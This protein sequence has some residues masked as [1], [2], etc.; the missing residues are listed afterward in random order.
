MERYD[1][2]IIG[3]GPS[4]SAAA[5]ALA[6]S[7]LNVLVVERGKTPGSKNVFGGRIYSYPLF[8]LIPDWQK[9]CPVERYVTKDCFAFMTE[10]QS[11]M[12]QF[13]SP[14]L[15]LGRGASFTALRSQ[16]DNWLAQKAESAGATLITEIKVD[17]LW[18]EGGRARG[19]VA[20]KD[21]IGADVVIAADGVVSKFTQRLGLRAELTPQMVSIGI[22]ETVA[23]PSATIQE[24]FGVNEG[25]GAAYVLAG[26]ASGHL[27]GGGFIYTNKESVSLGLVVSSE[28]VSINKVEVQ[29][30][31]ENFKRH[32][33]IERLLRGGKVIEYSTHMIPELGMST[34]RRAYSDGFLAVGDAAGFL[35]NNGYTFRGVDLAIASGMAAAEAVEVARLRGDFSDVTLAAYEGILR[36]DGVL[37]DLATFQK[38][39]QYMSNPRLY[40]LYPKLLCDVVERIFMIDGSGQQKAMDAVLAEIKAKNVSFFSLL[41]DFIGGALS[42]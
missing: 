29:S 11:L 41:R 35:I 17:D 22:K 36:R 12:V 8:K 39:P 28:D 21:K 42:M 6:K 3:A 26:Y 2:V 13:E 19:I 20:G 30:L 4:G 15:G 14:R 10:D 31:Q 23:L 38:G 34:L 5:L 25:E 27:R 24:R 7:G 33:T 37:T 9:D 18:F 1:V 32:P 16:F 40:S